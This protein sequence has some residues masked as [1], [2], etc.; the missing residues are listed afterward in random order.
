MAKI[1]QF[2][3]IFRSASKQPFEPEDVSVDRVLI[4]T[5]KDLAHSQPFVDEAKR[6]LGVFSESYQPEWKLISGEQFSSVSGLLE[7]VNEFRP[8]LIC[9][10]RNL[11]IPAS[12][13]PYS[14]G[15]YVD[16]LTQA[17]TTP[18]LLMPRMEDQTEFEMDQL[19]KTG[20]AKVMAITDHLAGDHHL[21]N[22]A[23]TLVKTGGKLYL[24][25]VEDRA[26][27]DRFVAAID[28]IAE[29]DSDI[30]RESILNQL[31]SEPKDYIESCRQTIEEKYNVEVEAIV[32]VGHLLKEHLKLIESHEIDLLILHTK[33]DD[34]LAMH[35][36]AY[37]LAVEMRDRP[38]LLI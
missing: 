33:D 25:H 17:M 35:G 36:L 16:V 11:H 7:Q 19:A 31:L 10:Y 29:I 21:V 14:L 22:M 38:L 2:E 5:D 37:P 3:S 30:A 12:E 9:T 28:R 20:T 34:Q 1:D 18:I 27:F 26:I 8:D 15:V 6:F 13:H 4:L 32:T 24:T 23:A